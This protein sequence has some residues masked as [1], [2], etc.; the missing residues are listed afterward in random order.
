MGK[1]RAYESYKDSG[2]EWLGEIPEHW[3]SL[4]VKYSADILR[5]KFTH[6]PRNDPNFYDGQHPFIQTGDV[7]N[8][9]K[10]ITEYTQT[11]NDN[12]YEVSKEFPAGTLVMTIAANIGDIAI[13]D[14]NACFPDSIVGFLP[15]K[16]TEIFFLYYLFT[17]MKQQLL[18]TAVLN[19]QL[20]LNIER[21][22]NQ[23]TAI[24]PLEEQKTIARF[25]DYKTKQIDALIAKKE[26]LL[27]KLD[28]KRTALIS[29]AVTKGLDATVPMKDSGIEWLGDIP[30]H[31]LMTRLRFLVSKIE[32]GW[33]PS[34]HNQ[35]AEANEWG[36]L[37]AGCVNG[38]TFDENE[39]KT[40]PDELEPKYQYEVRHGDILMSRANTKELLGSAAIAINPCRKLILCDKLYRLSAKENVDRK[41]LI[42]LLRSF[43]AR[44][45]YERDATGSS[46][47]MQNIGQ[48][49]IKDL[50]L[51]FPSLDKQKE[52]AE[53]LDRKTAEIDGQKEKIQQAIALLKEYRTALITNAVT[54]KID[55]RQVLDSP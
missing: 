12:G 5:G 26:A 39:N 46:G 47:S 34:C 3:E 41:Y 31:W 45:Q 53:Y 16:Q 38:E 17:S 32:Q 48:D 14:F 4:K 28:E 13:L 19:T 42:R 2:V 18:T 27:E 50:I 33:S 9:N 35:P 8:A 7:A 54:G 23:F 30:E 22:S 43:I 15:S 25:L 51:P 49:T 36:V 40:L 24:P 6:R 37:K 20:N 52:I 10:F 44:F 29:H 11:L 1:Y 55:V 21:I